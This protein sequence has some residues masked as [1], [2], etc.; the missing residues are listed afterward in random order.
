MRV[1]VMVV[2]IIIVAAVSGCTTRRVYEPAATALP[3]PHALNINTATA[4]ELERLPGIGR[5]TAEAIVEYRTENGAFRR[6]EHIMQIRG[7]SE[8]RF[9]EIR[10]LLK[11]E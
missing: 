6:V 8:R 2:A 11:T 3:S 1:R 9:I 4:E 5:K 10:H 7:M